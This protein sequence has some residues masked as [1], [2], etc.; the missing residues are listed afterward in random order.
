[1]PASSRIAVTGATGFIGKH[2]VGALSSRG[3]RV[4]AIARRPAPELLPGV[5]QIVMQD[6]NRPV[7][8]M[9]LLENAEVVIHLAGI[10]HAGGEVPTA[11]YNQVNHLGTAALADA[12]KRLRARLIFVSSVAAQVAPSADRIVTERDPAAPT[13]SYGRSKHEAERA[14]MAANGRYIILR[15]TLVYGADVKAN[16][17]KLVQLAK[18]PLPLPFASIDNRRS[19][20]GIDNLIHAV[21]FLIARE[22][23]DKEIFLIA[24]PDPVSLPEMISTIREGM[25]RSPNLISLPPRALATAFSLLKRSEIWERLS[26]NLVVSTEHLRG[27]GYSPV[28]STGEGLIRLGRALTRRQK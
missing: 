7:D 25:G 8:W 15:P 11:V 6:L 9:A 23:I 13:S 17:A 2:L 24:D 26:G 19:L 4:I 1:M 16:M 10:A 5:Q 21:E 14:I 28:E 12:V 27:A 22:E 18:L 20:L 3:H